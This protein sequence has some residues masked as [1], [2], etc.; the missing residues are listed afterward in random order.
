MKDKKKLNKLEKFLIREFEA[1]METAD[2][3]LRDEE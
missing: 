2:R 1:D 3:F